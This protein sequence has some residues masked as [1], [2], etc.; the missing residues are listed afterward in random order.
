MPGYFITGTDTGCGKTYVTLRLA[1]Q[2]IA[3]GYDVGVMKPF[4]TGPA[5]A[6]DARLL[7]RK[8]KLKD[9]LRLINPIHLKASL[10]PLA[11]A[12]LE[13]RKLNVKRIDQAFKYLAKRHEI[14]LVEGIGGVMVPLTDKLL[15]VDLI[16]KLKIPV[17]IVARAGLGTINHTLLTVAAL[18]QK[19]VPILGI[20][21]NGYRGKE[22]SEKTN[23]EIIGQLTKLPIIAKLR[24]R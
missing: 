21:I 22:R 18:R 3:A 16:K 24:W 17:I 19:K 23:A 10:A 6:D 12:R 15:V 13:R 11:A 20:I 9:P 8:L 2:L 14:V 5:A 7:K 4:S 1:R